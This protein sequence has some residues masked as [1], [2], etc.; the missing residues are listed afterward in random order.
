MLDDDF[1][2]VLFSGASSFAYLRYMLGIIRQRI[3]RTPGVTI[4]HTKSAVFRNGNAKKIYTQIDGEYAGPTP[5][6]V[7]IVSDALLL[8]LP[9]EYR[10]RRGVSAS[11]PAWTTSPTR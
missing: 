8:L 10:A 9:E 3:E 11:I 6:G 7:E 2:L 5:A 4:L 1:E